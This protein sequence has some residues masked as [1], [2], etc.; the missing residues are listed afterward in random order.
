VTVVSNVLR[1]NSASVHAEIATRIHELMESL[2]ATR[3]E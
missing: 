2:H 1:R 3:G